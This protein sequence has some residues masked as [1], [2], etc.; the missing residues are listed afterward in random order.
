M[1]TFSQTEDLV[2]S[3]LKNLGVTVYQDPNLAMDY[4]ILECRKGEATD[5]LYYSDIS[6]MVLQNDEQVKKTCKMFAD[7]LKPE[8]VRSY[9][10]TLSI[11]DEF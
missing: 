2:I 9:P 4:Y 10:P 5:E 6:S 7:N 1:R 11:E 8:P 3:N